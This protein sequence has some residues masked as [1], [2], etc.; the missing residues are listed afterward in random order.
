MTAAW[1]FVIDK[2]FGLSEFAYYMKLKFTQ[3]EVDLMQKTITTPAV[4]ISRDPRKRR[5]VLTFRRVLL[6][7]RWAAN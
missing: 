5:V 2:L 6:A 4:D 1:S 7:E 3:Q